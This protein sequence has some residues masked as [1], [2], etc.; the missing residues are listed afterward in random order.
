MAARKG[1]GAG[2]D[3]R[4]NRTTVVAAA[5]SAPRSASGSREL[6]IIGGR[7]RGRRWQFPAGTD[8]R[9]TPDR[10]RETLFNWLMQVTPGSQC[11]DVFAGSGALGLEALSRGAAAVTFIETDRQSAASLR[12][13]L[14]DWSAEGATVIDGDA[15]AWLEQ[16]A[17]TPV[18]VVFL[19]PPF[20]AGLLPRAF[21]ALGSRG[22]LKDGAQ[23]YAECA[24]GDS[25]LAAA[26][27]G[28][29][30]HRSGQA[31]EVGYHLLKRVTATRTS[32]NG[33]SR[34]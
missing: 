10:V 7:W 19:D 25:P 30:V 15:L 29:T 6:R 13:R 11:L 1:S 5:R 24:A 8:I 14:R 17:V 4:G 34:E 9:P 18:D 2:S 12:E 23:V 16:S 21:A 33:E 31:G 28:W 20:A 32:V 27:P 22:W 3:A 26:G